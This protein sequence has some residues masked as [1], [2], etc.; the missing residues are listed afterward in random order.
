M[1]KQKTSQGED[2]KQEEQKKNLEEVAEQD[3][4]NLNQN[5]YFRQQLLMYLER[6]A[7]ALEDSLESSEEEESNENP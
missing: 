2:N 6:I 4:I 3:Q 1:M 5:G 7:K